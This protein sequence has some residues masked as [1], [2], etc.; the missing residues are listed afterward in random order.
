MNASAA[1]DSMTEDLPLDLSF[2]STSTPRDETGGKFTGT[3]NGEVEGNEDLLAHS[4]TAGHALQQLNLDDSVTPTTSA[5]TMAATKEERRPV[6]QGSGG[7]H[8]ELNE[9]LPG[10]QMAPIN[11]NGKK[12]PWLDRSW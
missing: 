6:K 7:V 4:P 12:L 5:E 10:V 2:L 1:F 9:L 3:T 11:E 8:S